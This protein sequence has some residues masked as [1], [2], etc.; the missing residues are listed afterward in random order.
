MSGF[1]LGFGSTEKDFERQECDFVDKVVGE[2]IVSK[3][4]YFDEK[5]VK[6]IEKEIQKRADRYQKLSEGYRTSEKY[7]DRYSYYFFKLLHDYTDLV[8][9]FTFMHINRRHA[10]SPDGWALLRTEKLYHVDHYEITK[11]MNE[12][13]MEREAKP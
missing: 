2:H 10:F 3:D 4:S 1:V 11:C 12:Q 8:V 7:P 6:E 13:D 5:I 9:I